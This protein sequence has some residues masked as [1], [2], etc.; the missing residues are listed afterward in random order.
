MHRQA[1]APRTVRDH[2]EA[3]MAA[4]PR[5]LGLLPAPT[6]HRTA[7]PATHHHAHAKQPAPAAPRPA[8][9]T[10]ATTTSGSAGHVSPASGALPS[11]GEPTATT[12]AGTAQVGPAAGA[13]PD[14]PALDSVRI[15]EQAIAAEA[16]AA[17]AAPEVIDLQIEGLPDA[18]P[19][20]EAFELTITIH[21]GSSRPLSRVAA[22]V[23]FAEQIEPVGAGTWPVR[24]APGV[25]AF[26]P[27]DCVAPGETVSL[28]I[29][30]V[31][32]VAGDCAYRV[33]LECPEMEESLVADG[34]LTVSAPATPA[35]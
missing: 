2:L 26:D 12:A 21:N 17:P 14:A 34:S 15:V 9:A 5:P 1:A 28:P 10:A 25:I 22:T 23:F 32:V 29:R 16:T 31:G 3:A 33:T 7:T 13:G 27:L 20:G 35:R 11:P 18:T 4:M 6:L 30:A 19:T 8:L 24:L